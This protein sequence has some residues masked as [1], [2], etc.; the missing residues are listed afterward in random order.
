VLLASMFQ[1]YQNKTTIMRKRDSLKQ[2]YRFLKDERHVDRNEF[3]YIDRMKKE[4]KLPPFLSQ[5]DTVQL[6]DSIEA[7]SALTGSK[8]LD[9]ALTRGIKIYRQD[10][11]LNIPTAG[12][13]SEWTRN[14]CFVKY[15]TKQKLALICI[16]RRLTFA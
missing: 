12:E 3:D 7:S 13:T 8:F 14:E 15:L 16:A 4:H 6:L 5:A 10:A 1:K 11:V 9:R 2:F